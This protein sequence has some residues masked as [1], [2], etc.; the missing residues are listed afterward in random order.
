[1]KWS[2]F[3]LAVVASLT[4]SAS[5]IA[6]IAITSN[7]T[8]TSV[9]SI[10]SETGK[11]GGGFSI[12]LPEH[13]SPHQA[14]LLTMAYEIAKEDGHKQPQLLQGIL[15]QETKA[16]AMNTYKVAGQEYGLKTNERY[17]GIFQIKLAA[18]KEVL[19]KY[20]VV[21]KE[22]HFQTHTD[23]EIIAKLIENEKFSTSIASKYLLI[24]KQY[25]YNTIEQLSAAYN[26]GAGGAKK[27][28][29]HTFHYSVGVMK[30]IQMLKSKV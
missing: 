18:A 9:I 7:T 3:A 12:K 22:F 1:M 17:Y 25:G 19:S 30:N 29:P 20:P 10:A 6:M 26:Q 8:P 5:A 13:L 15:L 28:D 23:E 24:L 2:N 4:I 21:W 27:V 14:Q 11:V 16:G